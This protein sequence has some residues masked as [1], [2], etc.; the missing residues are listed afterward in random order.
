MTP[1][2]PRCF[3]GNPEAEGAGKSEKERRSDPHSVGSCGPS[4]HTEKTRERDM[5]LQRFTGNWW[6]KSQRQLGRQKLLTFI[7][8]QIRDQSF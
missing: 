5:A 2:N 3:P 8:A 6:A 4:Y 7:K 1:L